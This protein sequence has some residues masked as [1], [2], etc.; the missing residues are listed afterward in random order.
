MPAACP[1]KPAEVPTFQEYASQWLARRADA[2]YFDAVV[3]TFAQG[4]R[5]SL[6][7]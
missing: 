7:G 4:V 1:P 5:Q 2:G 3:V 6:H